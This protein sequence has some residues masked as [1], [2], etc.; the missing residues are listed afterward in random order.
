MSEQKQQHIMRKER[1]LQ[2]LKDAET[3]FLENGYE[4]E[5][6]VVEAQSDNVVNG[7][8]SIA[9]IGEF[10]AGKSTFLN[11]L[12]GERLL[13]SFSRETTATINFLRHKDQAKNGEA[14]LVY[15]ADGNTKILPDANFETIKRYVCTDSPEKVA[16]TIS[17]LDLFLDNKFLKDNVTLVDTPGLNGLK[18]GHRE[19]TE[20]QIERSSASIFLFSAA[21]PGSKSDFEALS[22]LHKRV[23]SI[24]LVLNYIDVI[25]A[26]ESVDAVIDDLKRKY[27]SDYP[28]E[29]TIPEIFPVSALKAL[30][31]RSAQAIEFHERSDF[32]AEEKARFER[33]SLLETFEDR[34][35]R[36]LTQGEKGRQMLLS[37]ME[38]LVGT[39]TDVSDRLNEEKNVLSSKVDAEEL[40]QRSLTL[41]EILRKLDVEI[42]KQT[43]GV[44]KT[45]T[46]VEDDFRREITAGIAKFRDEYLDRIGKFTSIDEIDP[47]NITRTVQR[48]LKLIIDTAYANYGT[49]IEDICRNNNIDS[50]ELGSE[51]KELKVAINQ[52]LVV[53]NY[54]LGIESFEKE[55][56]LYRQQE[57]ELR[58]NAERAEDNVYEHM[59][60]EKKLRKLEKEIGAVQ[61][62][63]RWY[64]ENARSTI[65]SIQRNYVTDVVER[66]RGGLL[67][68]IA[69]FF[70]GPKHEVVGHWNTDDTEQKAYL[71]DMQKNLSTYDEKISNLEAELIQYDSA[72]SEAARRKE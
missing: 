66:K 41:S 2:V 57:K 12:M 20:R 22:M 60:M 40:E 23:K 28:E 25:H 21:Q 61:E 67:G 27:K 55:I 72:D 47:A 24:L 65:P 56:D 68:S 26:D 11:A 46:E 19:L 69:G 52:E 17:H 70:V 44:R 45:V 33:E 30:V 62:R 38:Q 6:K 64:E 7:E 63:R 59:K 39:L 58:A 13:P 48:K 8:F 49:G 29:T 50:A 43:A 51:L 31:A 3:F 34:L 14:G 42:Q 32:T 35:W 16:E 71:A 10:S 4:R 37:P 1:V 9:V 15:Y 5:A 18:E 53:T 54:D 36:Y